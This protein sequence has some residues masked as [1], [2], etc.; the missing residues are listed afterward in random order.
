MSLFV[1][2]V[3][4]V[5]YTRQ[6]RIEGVPN[7]VPGDSFMFSWADDTEGGMEYFIDFL[8]GVAVLA[9]LWIVISIII[10]IAIS[11]THKW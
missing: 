3:L 8:I 9:G 1:T 5:C 4:M 2:S 6:K 11:W 10:S 7:T